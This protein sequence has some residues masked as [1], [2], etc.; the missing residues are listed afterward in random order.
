[1]KINIF[2]QTKKGPWGGGNQFVL[3]LTKYLKRFNQ[4]AQNPEDADAILFNL[5]PSASLPMLLSRL[6]ILKNKHPK[7]L[8]FCRIDGPVYL[9]RNKDLDLDHAF[10]KLICAL[11]DGVIFQSNWSR[12]NNYNLGLKHH[13]FE[14]VIMNASDPNIFN[15]HG[16]FPFSNKRK[17]RLI[18]T[19]WSS[20]WRKGFE[21]Y[22]WLDQHLNFDKFEL[23][24]AGNT[25][26]TFSNIKHIPPLDSEK[27]A[28]LLKYNDIYLT[29]SQK[30]PCSNALI[31]ALSC[32]LP[33][34]AKNDGGHP[35][36]VGKGGEL[37]HEP[38]EIP[39]LLHNIINNYNTYQNNIRIQTMYHIGKQYVD[40]I[41]DIY[42][43]VLLKKYTPKLFTNPN[44]MSIYGRIFCWKLKNK[45]LSIY[46]YF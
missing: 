12:Q 30:D 13:E 38:Q 1:M 33:S 5:N 19:S 42:D 8:V 10:Y 24:F 29:A 23:T 31:E 3:A 25:P 40:F 2:Y 46:N 44:Y 35:E 37:F 15:N 43:N 16:K 28:D 39:E 41:N 14:K 34:L 4:Y 7:K 45:I 20:N 36:I 17:P 11:S 22:N 21:I 32:G 27:L 6:K 9:V 18:I 26:I